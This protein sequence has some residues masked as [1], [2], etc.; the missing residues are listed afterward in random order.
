[1]ATTWPPKEAWNATCDVS[2]DA[3]VRACFGAGECL[4]SEVAGYHVCACHV[5]YDPLTFCNSSIFT[6][7]KGD[8]LSYPIVRFA[9]LLTFAPL[10][11]LLIYACL[12]WLRDHAAYLSRLCARGCARSQGELVALLAAPQE[13]GLLHEAPPY[14]HGL[15]CVAFPPVCVPVASRPQALQWIMQ[16]PFRNSSALLAFGQ[17]F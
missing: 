7:Y 3:N 9:K 6:A 13:A 17:H 16:S 15:K 14:W 12:D 1:M 5:F 10:E 11:C 4:K 2:T 8:D